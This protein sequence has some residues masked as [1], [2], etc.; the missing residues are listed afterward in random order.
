MASG[1]ALRGSGWTASLPCLM[2]VQYVPSFRART[3]GSTLCAYQ[4]E[5]PQVLSHG[6]GIGRLGP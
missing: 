6:Y 3:C 2:T 5:T 1:A 4:P